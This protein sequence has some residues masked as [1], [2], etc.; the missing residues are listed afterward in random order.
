MYAACLELGKARKTLFWVNFKTAVGRIAA[1]R[2]AYSKFEFLK[3]YVGRHVEV[4][5]DQSQ[6]APRTPLESP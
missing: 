4:T 6:A 3:R 1:I 2:C 5:S